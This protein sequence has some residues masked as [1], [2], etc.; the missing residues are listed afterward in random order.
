MRVG[1]PVELA[2]PGCRRRKRPVDTRVGGGYAS[3]HH[4]QRLRHQIGLET[5]VGSERIKAAYGANYERLC[6][7][8]E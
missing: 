4:R 5:D 2:G 8:E 7:C 3:L 6:G 1:L